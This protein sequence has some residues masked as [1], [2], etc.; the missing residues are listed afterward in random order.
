MSFTGHIYLFFSFFQSSAPWCSLPNAPLLW[1]LAPLFRCCVVLKFSFLYVHIVVIV[2]IL[3]QMD[4]DYDFIEI[5]F[6]CEVSGSASYSA[7]CS[8]LGFQCS[9]LVVFGTNG[10]SS[11]HFSFAE[12]IVKF[13]FIAYD[14]AQ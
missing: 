3:H 10:L 1:I 6:L 11:W 7:F 5:D 2:C 13:Y 9:S 14:L 8:F 12:Y 4:D